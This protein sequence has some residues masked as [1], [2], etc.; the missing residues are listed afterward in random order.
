MMKYIMN[1]EE[2]KRIKRK[3]IMLKKEMIVLQEKLLDKCE[4]CDK[5]G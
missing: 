3:I 4:T 2:V 5:N 1:N